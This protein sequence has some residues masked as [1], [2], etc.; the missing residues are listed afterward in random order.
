MQSKKIVLLGMAGV[1]K[2]TL[3]KLLAK[4]YSLPFI[5]LDLEIENY[6]KEPLQT[7][8]DRLG[9]TAFLDLEK[10]VFEQL[11]HQVAVYAPGG[12]FIYIAHHFQNDFYFVYL[13]ENTDTLI[14][15]LDNLDTRGIVGIKNNSFHSLV[16]ERALLGKKYADL[17]IECRNRPKQQI[18]DE[19]LNTLPTN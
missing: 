19:I 8:L 4:N 10:K 18:V 13:N 12:S 14:Q 3:G 7:S 15:R 6:T 5:D 1:G 9:D 17:F 16:E 2:S 11:S